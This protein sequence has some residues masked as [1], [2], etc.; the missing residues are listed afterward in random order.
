MAGIKKYLGEIITLIGGIITTNN[1]LRF[2]YTTERGSLRA[3]PSLG[4]SPIQGVA[5]YYS[6]EVITLLTLGV[7]LIVLGVLILRKKA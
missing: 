4:D 1:I 3:L 7:A 5:Y 6:S 2:S